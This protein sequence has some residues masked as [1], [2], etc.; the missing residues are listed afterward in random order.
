MKESFESFVKALKKSRKECPWAKER[1]I[2]TYVHELISEANEVLAAVEKRDYEN[3]KEE[4]GDLLWDLLFISII[5]EEKGLFT[6]KEMVDNAREKLI[7]RK[8]WVFGNEN[9][10]TK[11]NAIKRWNELKGMEKNKKIEDKK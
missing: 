3:L 2:E 5:A 11:E 6:I 4:L 9:I 1:E 7:R 10:L 8:P